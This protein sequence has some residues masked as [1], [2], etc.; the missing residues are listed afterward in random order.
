ML[1]SCHCELRL[2]SDRHVAGSCSES[3][4]S[5]Q[6]VPEFQSH[7]HAAPQGTLRHKSYQADRTVVGD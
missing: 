3:E 5:E 6:Y 4:D 1:A 7:H 2:H